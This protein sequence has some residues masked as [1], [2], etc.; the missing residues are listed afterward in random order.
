MPLEL[1]LL[2][3]ARL[4]LLFANSARAV[5][6]IGRCRRLALGVAA[7]PVSAQQ[8]EAL[9]VSRQ[10]P[11]G[12]ESALRGGSQLPEGSALSE[13]TAAFDNPVPRA[14]L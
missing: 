8:L 5:H 1:E 14:A 3:M 9:W 12:Y 7:Q 2:T 4:S 6:Q 11:E 10:L 13:P